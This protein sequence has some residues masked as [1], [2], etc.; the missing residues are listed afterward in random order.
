MWVTI[1][2]RRGPRARS[3][4]AMPRDD[5]SAITASASGASSAK[6]KMT[7]FVSGASKLATPDR[8]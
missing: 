1:R 4:S 8:P 5:I 6:S 3:E 2:I 7:M